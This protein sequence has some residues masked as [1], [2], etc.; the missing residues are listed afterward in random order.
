MCTV[1]AIIGSSPSFSVLVLKKAANSKANTVDSRSNGSAYNKNPS[2][3]TFLFVPM[4]LFLLL[5]YNGYN[6]VT[7]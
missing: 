2:L 3:T 7:L 4:Q 1:L 5:L 6:N